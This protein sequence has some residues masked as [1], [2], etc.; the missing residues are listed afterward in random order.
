MKIFSLSL[1]SMRYVVRGLLFF[2]SVA[3]FLWIVNENIPL[4]GIKKIAYTF[5]TPNG[6]ITQLRPMARLGQSGVENGTSFQKIIE[7][8]VYFD[9]RT[10]VTYDTMV[11]EV[12]YKNHTSHELGVGIKQFW[13]QTDFFVTPFKEIGTQGEW[14]MGRAEISL[15][16]IRRLPGRYSLSLSLPGLVYRPDNDEYVLVSRAQIVLKK[17]PLT[18]KGMARS[19]S[20]ILYKK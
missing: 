10:P 7:N 18:L 9:V 11:V 8:P 3:F 19:I 4:A 14:K 17:E 20:E 2:A 15:K 1:S 5:G 13:T 16:G 12:L 6:I